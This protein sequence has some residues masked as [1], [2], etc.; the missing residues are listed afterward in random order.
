MAVAQTTA[1]TI[2]AKERH[3]GEPTSTSIGLGKGWKIFSVQNKISKCLNFGKPPRICWKLFVG[4]YSSL[5]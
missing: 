1:I 2:E 3:W 5:L 4:N